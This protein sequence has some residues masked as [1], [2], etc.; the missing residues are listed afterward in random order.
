MPVPS[1]IIAIAG[2]RV[3]EMVYVVLMD[4]LFVG[5]AISLNPAPLGPDPM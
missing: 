4:P 5:A 1:F 3:A 2:C